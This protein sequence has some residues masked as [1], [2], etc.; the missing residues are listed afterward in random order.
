M[1]FRSRSQVK[2]FGAMVKRKEISR[3]T[4]REWL[5]KTP[6]VKSLPEKVK[7]QSRRIRGR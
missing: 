3:R 5:D 6:S 2:K 7:K 1:P 4:F